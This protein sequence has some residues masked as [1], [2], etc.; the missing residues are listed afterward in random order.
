MPPPPALNAASASSPGVSRR[1]SFPWDTSVSSRSD[2]DEHNSL[3][4]ALHG[5]E[6]DLDSIID[7]VLDNSSTPLLNF[8]SQRSAS[9]IESA[10]GEKQMMPAT[11][12][13]HYSD[14]DVDRLRADRESGTMSVIFAGMDVVR[15]YSGLSRRRGSDAQTV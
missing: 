2:Q 11:L 13:R 3:R 15:N 7:N 8:D 5:F 14:S 9:I 1:S 10:W 4:E 12:R 6:F